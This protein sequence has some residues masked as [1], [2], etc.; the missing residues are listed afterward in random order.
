MKYDLLPRCRSSSKR[1][2]PFSPGLR[3][4]ISFL[5][6]GVECCVAYGAILFS[7]SNSRALAKTISD[8]AEIERGCCAVR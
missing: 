6:L 3:G 7:I 5:A 4:F 2:L 1:Q 8:G